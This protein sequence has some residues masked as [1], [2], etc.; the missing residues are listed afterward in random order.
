MWVSV[1][2][3]LQD[4]GLFGIIILF[5]SVGNKQTILSYSQIVDS[6]WICIHKLFIIFSTDMWITFINHD[7][8]NRLH[9]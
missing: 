3:T 5:S 9:K 2:I 1:E 6:L 4:I 7:K 8:L